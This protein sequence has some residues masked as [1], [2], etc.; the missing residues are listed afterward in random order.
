MPL[1]FASFDGIQVVRNHVELIEVQRRDAFAIESGEVWAGK[2]DLDVRFSL[3]A[4]F[5]NN[6]CNLCAVFNGGVINNA[7]DGSS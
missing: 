3:G 4:F 1:V 7:D 5:T 6:G 2:L